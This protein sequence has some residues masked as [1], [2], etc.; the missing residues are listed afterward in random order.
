MQKYLIL[1]YVLALIIIR[2]EYYLGINSSQRPHV[3]LVNSKINTLL[4]GFVIMNSMAKYGG[5]WVDVASG[6]NYY[7]FDT[8]RWSDLPCTSN[9]CTDQCH[10]PSGT[11]SFCGCKTCHRDKDTRIC[12]T[13]GLRE[14]YIDT[15][16][17]K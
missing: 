2:I 15:C 10:Q 1:K 17:Q 5:N 4:K 3:C 7:S 6:S 11:S 13:C 12:A 9:G 16:Q 14:H 8:K